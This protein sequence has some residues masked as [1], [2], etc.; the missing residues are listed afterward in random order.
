MRSKIKFFLRQQS[1]IRKPK[2]VRCR[3]NI[4]LILLLGRVR[5]NSSRSEKTCTSLVY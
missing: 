4:C 1:A 3:T 2:S 5:V